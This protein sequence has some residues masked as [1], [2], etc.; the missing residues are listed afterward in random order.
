MVEVGIQV[1][2]VEVGIQVE[3][4]GIQVEVWAE[5][6]GMDLVEVAELIGILVEVTEAIGMVEVAEVA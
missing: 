1:E 2:M 6:L 5:A 4:L 3:V